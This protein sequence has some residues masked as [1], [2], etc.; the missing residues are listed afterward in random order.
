M[1]AFPLGHFRAVIDDM[2]RM[3]RFPRT[4][5]P[6]GEVLGVPESL[7]GEVP[8]GGLEEVDEVDVEEEADEEA[9]LMAMGR[10]A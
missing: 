9:W 5:V 6:L 8:V 7:D 1:G 10:E 3:V 4:E 2:E